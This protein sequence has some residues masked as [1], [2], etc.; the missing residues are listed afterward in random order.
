MGRC[1]AFSRERR[2][3]NFLRRGPLAQHLVNARLPSWTSGAQRDQ[4]VGIQAQLHGHF[5][6]GLCSAGGTTAL[7]GGDG[8]WRVDG[9]KLVG[10]GLADGFQ[11]VLL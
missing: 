1:A 3:R 4:N 10:L 8:L 2:A 7:A 9:G 5:G 6:V 11:Q